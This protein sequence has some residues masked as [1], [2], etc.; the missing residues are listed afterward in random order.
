MYFT[1]YFTPGKT[2]D[3]SAHAAMLNDLP[4]GQS[5]T[6]RL[7]I[8]TFVPTAKPPAFPNSLRSIIQ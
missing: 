4:Y 5:G 1:M 2:F 8:F 7:T 3:I 6:G